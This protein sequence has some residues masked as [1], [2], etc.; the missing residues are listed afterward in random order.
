MK[1]QGRVQ[2]GSRGH[3][4]RAA[5][6][7]AA[8]LFTG[9]VFGENRQ[10]F[11][12]VP[13]PER[14]G[15]GPSGGAPANQLNPEPSGGNAPAP[16][17]P[18]VSSPVSGRTDSFVVPVA[19]A[20]E[21]DLLFCVDNSLSMADNQAI[22]ADSFA[23]FIRG[24]LHAGVDFHVGIVTSDVDSSRASIWA[25]RMPG[26]PGANRGLLLSRVAGERFLTAQSS[27][28]VASFE[29]TVR[30]GTGGS[31]RE[32]C[33]ESFIYALANASGSGWNSGFFRKNSLHAFVVVSDENEDIQNGEAI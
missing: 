3:L 2:A 24:F 11:S 21:L 15:P 27:G 17:A 23:G 16:Q 14:V 25:S 19:G 22:L 9:C 33:L 28:L 8:V 13:S 31:S 6:F 26:Y 32:Q 12:E 30:V 10:F 1:N 4:N 29:S 20:P 7:G 5:L 18:Q